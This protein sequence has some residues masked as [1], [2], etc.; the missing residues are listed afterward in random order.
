MRRDIRQLAA[1]D[2]EDGY[3]LTE[4]LVV[5]G[6][7]CLIAA[8]LTPSLLGQMARSRA[9]AAQLQLDMTAANVE[10]FMSDVHRYP[11]QEEGLKALVREP[12]GVD[13][14]SGPY[15]RD[16]RSLLDPWNDPIIYKLAP[17][18][19][20]FVVVSLGADGKPGGSGV[21]RDLQSP[22][23]AAPVTP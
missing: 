9:K 23:A 4:M 13:G 1:A 21:N 14:W 3:T 16:P 8:V 11:T 20:S 10:Q 17:D 5:I 12:A 19:R 6:I 18:G 2:R 7:I 22:A 15:L